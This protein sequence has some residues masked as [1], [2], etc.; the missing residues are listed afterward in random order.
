PAA[1]QRRVKVGILGIR[2]VIVPVEVLVDA[3]LVPVRRIDV[4]P[5]DMEQ[6][7]FREAVSEGQVVIHHQN[8]EYD[9]ARMLTKK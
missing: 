9:C 6:Q 4:N 1:R 8:A 5:W 3:L 7:Q 2:F